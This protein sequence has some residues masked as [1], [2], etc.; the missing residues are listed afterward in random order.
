MSRRS[1]Q[2]V[3]LL[4]IGGLYWQLVSAT[5]G[6]GEPWDAPAYWSLAYPFSLVLS[7]IGGAFMRKSGWIAGV[8]I[9]V[10]Q[11]P[12]MLLNNGVGNLAV[13]GALF[14]SLLAIPAA[15]VSALAG[16]LAGRFRPHP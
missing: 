16:S 3:C 9:T 1:I 13:A 6:Y 12:V 4:I 11:L 2:I 14:L 5:T 10:S 8:L 15:L 7:A